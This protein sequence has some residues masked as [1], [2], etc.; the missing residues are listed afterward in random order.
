MKSKLAILVYFIVGMGISISTRAETHS[1]DL[2][3]TNISFDKENLVIQADGYYP[4]PCV[5][6]A[7]P[8]LSPDSMD[9][10]ILTLTMV[11]TA[12]AEVCI[13]IL[14]PNFSQTLDARAIKHEVE[15]AGLNGRGEYNIQSDDGELI[16]I[17]NLDETMISMPAISNRISGVLINRDSQLVVVGTN[18]DVVVVRSIDL[19][20]ARYVGSEVEIYG[21]VFNGERP[22]VQFASMRKSENVFFV[23]GISFTAD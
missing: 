7:R 21:H 4:N 6:D 1:T 23:T 19:D 12:S 13:Q 14:G 22:G 17:V 5:K 9:Q 18:G 3:I 11:G 16:A 20:L 10:R 2:P 8:K 15:R